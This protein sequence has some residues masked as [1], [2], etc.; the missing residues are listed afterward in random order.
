MRC[1]LL[2]S[3]TVAGGAIPSISAED[4]P[5]L[6][7]I[8]DLVDEVMDLV[9]RATLANSLRDALRLCQ[10]CRALHTKLE[11]LR[12]LAEAR[13][14]RW[15]P[16]LTAK[17]AI[18][19]D[20]Y[21]LTVLGGGDKVEPWA[22][23]GLL[24]TAGRSAWTIRI[25]Q[26]RRND[27]NGMWVGVCDTA[28]RWGWGVSLYSGRLRRISRGALGQ[29]DFDAEPLE[30]YPNGN[31]K[32]LMRNQALSGLR[33]RAN[34]AAVEVL[35]D[36]DAGALGYRVNG[37]PLLEALPL[38]DEERC[39]RWSQ[40]QARGFPRGATLRPYATCYYQGDSMR[41]TTP[42]YRI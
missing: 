10:T 29:L 22:A 5:P 28:A 26:S 9:G 14:L 25:E 16:D 35:V 20:G 40:G 3:S 39:S 41:F 12:R 38:S 32:Q 15:L 19:D 37:G 21:R 36:H 24:P 8:L 27:G 42:F 33:S 11:A 6:H 1:P 2:V 17:H 34:G 13:R 4:A 7:T 31:Y 18:S 23:G 30:G